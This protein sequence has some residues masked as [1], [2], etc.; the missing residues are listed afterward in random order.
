MDE[1]KAQS[2]PYD[3]AFLFLCVNEVMCGKLREYADQ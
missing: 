1:Q 2:V 3:W